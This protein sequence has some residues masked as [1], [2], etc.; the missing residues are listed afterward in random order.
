MHARAS[1]ARVSKP[2][3]LVAAILMGLALAA[4]VQAHPLAP[5]LFEIEAQGEGRA[6]I[7][8][9]TSR[10]RPRGADIRPVLPEACPAVSDPVADEDQQSVTLRWQ[11]ECTDGGSWVG[12]RIAVRGLEATRIDVLVRIT[13]GDGRVMST[14]LRAGDSNFEIPARPEKIQVLEAYTGLGFEH[15]LTGPDHLLFVLG[16]VLLVVGARPL[17]KT[18]T[19]FTLGHSLTLSIAALGLVRVPSALIEILIAASVLLLAVELTARDSARPSLLRRKPWLM[20]F[21]FGLLHGMGFAG[22]LAEI[23]LPDDEIP[24]ALFAFNVGI[25]L[26]QLAFVAVI[27]VAAAALGGRLATLPGWLQRT[28]AYAIGSLAAYWMLQR[29]ASM[30]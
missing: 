30:F 2:G 1:K 21:G 12:R 10:L 22:A 29:T 3:P 23:G 8:W 16:L 6:E 18:V 17:I 9:K 28:P 24:L 15:I 13:L 27:L 4:S 5:A 7:A 11:V 25:E 26:G 14:V 19:A 20:A